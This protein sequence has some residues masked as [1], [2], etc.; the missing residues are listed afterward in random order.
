MS[1]KWASGLLLVQLSCYFSPG[2]CGKV[3]VWPTEYSHWMNMKTILD[4]LVWRGH[5]VTVLTASSSIL[6]DPGKSSIIKFEVYPTSL[7]KNDLKDTIMRL[8][9]AWTYVPKDTFWSHFSQVQEIMWEY[10]N[11]FKKFCE[12]VALNKTLM[13]KLKESKFDVI[14][15]DAIGPCGELLAQLFKIPFVYSLCMSPGYTLEKY[16]GG[17]LLPPSYVP[18]IMSELSDQMTFMERIKNMIY[19]L[20]FDFWF[21]PFDMKK[22]DQF[23]SKVLGRPTTFLETMGKADMWLIQ[24]YWDFEYP[25]PFLPNFDFV[26]GLHCKPAKALPK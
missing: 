12:D 7:T 5:E 14:L 13:T 19:V 6:V 2:N 15:A 23:Y 4:E 3:L 18:V 8:V 17:L 20:Y 25:R 1:M 26:G 11:I 16:S 9:D 21:Q 10:S 22:W 24:T